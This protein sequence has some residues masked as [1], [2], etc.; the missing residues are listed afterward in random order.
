MWSFDFDY[1]IL[2]IFL[3]FVFA[4]AG[5]RISKGE[6]P[7]LYIF[8]CVLVFTIVLGSRYLRGNDYERYQE[9]FLHD[10]DPEEILFTFINQLLRG[11]GITKYTFLYIYSIPFALCGVIFCCIFKEYVKWMLPCFFAAFVFFDEYCI[12]QALGFS[13]VFL[14][15]YYLFKIEKNKIPTNKG[16]RLCIKCFIC[17]LFA[18]GFH[19]VNLLSIM[20]ITGVYFISYRPI[21]WKIAIPLL[22]IAVLWISTAFDWTYINNGLELLGSTNSKFGRYTERSTK[23]FSDDAFKDDWT[24]SFGGEIFDIIGNCCLFYLGELILIKRAFPKRF[25][26]LFNIYV[27]GTIMDR[28]FWN[29]EL[30]RRVF[31][32]MFAFWCFPLSIVFTEKKRNKLKS[33]QKVLFWGLSFFFYDVY[34]KYLFQRGNMT[35]FLWDR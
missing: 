1:V 15:M 14:Y 24:R 6:N 3:T 12:R 4:F 16:G 26:V 25:I 33:W 29:F 8:L 11:I 20:L 35:L 22:L 7:R 31:D 34:F 2:N 17:I 18:Y 28:A 10:D 5:Y 13:F 30:V 23:F 32:P 27:I 19:S 21:S 9:T